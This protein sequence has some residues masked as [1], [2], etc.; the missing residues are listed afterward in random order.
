M[1]VTARPRL[2]FY[3]QILN[4][5]TPGVFDT[6]SRR[7]EL[8][9]YCTS[10]K[11]TNNNHAKVEVKDVSIQVDRCPECGYFLIWKKRDDRY[12]WRNK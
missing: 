7:P 8:T 1:R 9:A 12:N 4:D 6:P 11:C 2:G 10:N 5:S 3:G